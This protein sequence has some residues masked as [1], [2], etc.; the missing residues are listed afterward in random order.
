V[1]DRL[2]SATF[3]SMVQAT[4][5]RNGN[6]ARKAME[7]GV[8]VETMMI[9]RTE[10]TCIFN[11]DGVFGIHNIRMGFVSQKHCYETG[12]LKSFNQLGTHLPIW[13]EIPE[14]LRAAGS[15]LQFL[16]Q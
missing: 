4:Y 16:P 14:L 6:R 15:T 5:L 3:V 2:S 13:A 8:I 1:K 12:T 11:P 10:K 9:S 7:N